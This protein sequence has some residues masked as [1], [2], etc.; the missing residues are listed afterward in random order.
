[1]SLSVISILALIV[2]IIIGAVRKSNIGILCIGL[3]TI[4][5]AVYGIKPGEIIKGFSTSLFLTMAGVSYLFA[6]L[7]QNDTLTILA[8]KI[9]RLAG[10]RPILI[11]FMM[12]LSGVIISAVGPG[13]IPNMAI[14]PVLAVPIAKSAGLNPVLLS[15]AGQMGVQGGRMSPITPESVVVSQLLADQGLGMTTNTIPMLYCLLLTEILIFLCSFAYFKG[16]QVDKKNTHN[17]EL[18]ELRFSKEQKITLCGLFV[19]L[20]CVLILKMNV[21]LVSFMAGSALIVLGYGYE[22]E[23]IKSLPWNVIFMVLGVGILMKILMLSGGV[24]FM[25]NGLSSIMT[26]S[27]AASIMGIMGGIMS[28]FSSSLGVVIPTLVPTVSGIA[29]NL[30]GADPLELAAMVVIG[31]TVTGF[32]PISTGGALIMSAVSS[33]YEGDDSTSARETI[34]KEQ[35]KQFRDLFV[36]AFMALAVTVILSIFGVYRLIL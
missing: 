6:I 3:A 31:S 23:V 25:S 36:V 8:A 11:Y 20:F 18:K 28:F 33:N 17:V 21:G 5:G 34:A 16:W 32:S 35:N 29:S 10:N 13:A 1:M 27:T 4:L 22:K 7:M 9:V 30:P 2:A 15:L 19:M 26:A 12:F 24:E 14:I